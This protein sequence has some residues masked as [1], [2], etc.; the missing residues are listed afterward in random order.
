[1]NRQ[2]RRRTFVWVGMLLLSFLA[3]PVVWTQDYPTKPVTM[4]Y[5]SSPGGS[6]D[7]TFRAV[8][9]VA[10]DYLGQPIVIQGKVGSGGV[11]AT[12]FVAK[13]VP[14]GYTLLV[15]GP[16]WNT[17]LPAIEGRSKGPDDMAAVCRINYS[18]TI[19]VAR[20]ELPF[21]TFKEMVEYA[22]ANPNKLIFGTTGPWGQADLSWKQIM[23]KADIKTKSIPQA[24]GGAALV[25]MLGGHIDLTGGLAPVL[26]PHI[27][28]GKF[29]ALVILDSKR[30]PE[31]P[32]VPTGKEAG[33]DV[34]N[35]LWRGVV[36]P[37]GT[38]RPIID[39]LAVAFK[40]MTEDKSVISMIRQFGDDIQYLGPDE[41]AKFW[42]E[43]YKEH[44]ELGKI[45]K[46]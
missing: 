27:R 13:A 36:A 4:Y 34:V 46:P 23:K 6:H 19:I 3:V 45:L 31:L 11:I 37:K 2:S 38:P 8:T 21:K 33:V 20:A 7:L 42:Q 14:D 39:K 22:K 24:G 16:G 35:H 28:A 44:K 18:P 1:M 15:G 10:V 30:S 32:E 29:R 17:T 9:S 26:L 25:A 41:F 40:K 5:G 43:E 12:E